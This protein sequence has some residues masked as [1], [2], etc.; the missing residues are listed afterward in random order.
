MERK[1]MEFD[2]KEIT[3]KNIR[4]TFIEVEEM[5]LSAKADGERDEMECWDNMMQKLLTRMTAEQRSWCL[6]DDFSQ[7]PSTHKKVLA[8]IKKQ[9]SA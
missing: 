8:A 1:K 3:V 4:E 5:Y 6:D 7:I 2:G 9:E